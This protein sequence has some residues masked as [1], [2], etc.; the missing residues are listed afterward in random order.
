M[1]TGG[2]QEA[3]VGLSPE[4]GR[5][6]LLELC[7]LSDGGLP[8]DVAEAEAV[9]DAIERAAPRLDLDLDLE[10]P[11]CGAIFALPFDTTSFF[12]QEVR[13]GS[14]TLLREFHSLAFHYHWSEPEIL[15]LDRGRRRAYLS[16]LT[17]E[18]R[19]P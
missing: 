13:S 15:A 5:A 7:L 6:R 2:D 1:P 3:V 9:E 18:L 17:D 4:A 8:L 14:R 12:L 11:Y 16:L 19:R 10:C